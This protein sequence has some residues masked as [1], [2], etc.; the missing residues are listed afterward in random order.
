MNFDQQTFGR[1]ASTAKLLGRRNNFELARNGF[2]GNGLGAKRLVAVVIIVGKTVQCS[3]TLGTAIR[4][5]ICGR[6]SKKMAAAYASS[7]SDTVMRRA[8]WSLL[9]GSLFEQSS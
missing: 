1:G 7:S 3:I 8:Y 2:G 6:V 5:A 4:L 9:Q